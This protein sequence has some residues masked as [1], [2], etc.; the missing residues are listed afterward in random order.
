MKTITWPHIA[1]A[2]RL[3]RPERAGA[4]ELQGL[5]HLWH[6]LCGR[7]GGPLRSQGRWC[8]LQVVAIRH[9]EQALAGVDQPT[10]DAEVRQ[11]R[12]G[13]LRHGFRDDL[14][15]RAFALVCEV[16]ERT[17]GMRHFDSQLTGGLIMLHGMIAEM[18]TGEGKTLTATLTAAAAALAGWPVHVIS[19]ND[20]L[21]QRDAEEMGPVYNALGL[22]V[23]CVVHGQQPAERQSAYRADI[24]YCTNKEVTFDYLR[25]RL[26]LQERIS[27]LRL[28]A[29]D[30]LDN[31]QRKDRL[32]LPGLHFA[33]I[34]EA[35]SIL[36]DEART[37]LIISGANGDDQQQRF[38]E[39][40]MALARELVQDQHFK[41]REETSGV[42]LTPAGQQLL[43]ERAESLEPAWK[44][45]IR[46]E[47]TVTQALVALNCFHK[48]EQYVLQDGK[49]QIVDE[50]TGRIMADR[51]WEKGLHQLI[52][53][54]EECEVSGQRESL[55]RIS[56]QKFFRRYLRL[57]GMTGTA[58]EVRHELWDVYNLAVMKVP[59]HKKMQRKALPGRIF[60]DTASKWQAVVE[61]IVALREQGRPVLV[62]TRSV[63]ASETLSAWLQAAEVPH[64]VLNAKRDAEE[65]EIVAMAGGSQRVTIATNMAGRGTD[66]KLAQGVP[67]TGGLHVILT[68]RHEAGRIDRQLFGRCGRQGDPGSHEAFV[69]IDDPMLITRHA[70]WLLLLVRR[71]PGTGSK[72]WQKIAGWGILRTQKRVE[73]HYAGIRNR[74]LKQD[75]QQTALLSFSGRPD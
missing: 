21:T 64:G 25:D 7:L 67:D 62:G 16:S 33:I 68:E 60:P 38:F 47:S 70:S 46:R 32:I 51:S 37:P 30:L 66:I 11:V 53:V 44:G 36:V 52:E 14:V 22:S 3:Y 72:W 31:G 1:P 35:D 54:K 56:Y 34:D 2:D 57:C 18:Q 41:L 10:L 69:S 28:L 65:A 45:T 26:V 74:L 29:E 55:A 15:A 58:H 42:Y 63:A 6:R 8:R 48:D 23:G 49:V 73:T 19:V 12:E 40:A 13:L 4:G 43:S 75:L 39:Q 61:R 50:F 24:V 20:Y 59:T 5:N 9:H 17:L 71:L 27:P